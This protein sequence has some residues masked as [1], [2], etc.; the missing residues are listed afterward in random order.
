MLLIKTAVS[1]P[2]SLVLF[3]SPVVS[4]PAEKIITGRKATEG[5]LVKA[6]EV[7]VIKNPFIVHPSKVLF[8]AIG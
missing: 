4:A 1:F 7:R 8:G 3:I 2:S 6:S 5:L